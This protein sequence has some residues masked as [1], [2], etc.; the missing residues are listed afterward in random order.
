MH[1]S[2]EERMERLAQATWRLIA[3]RGIT[4]VSVRTVAE[5]AGVAVGSLRHLFPTQAALLEFSAKLMLDR[6]TARVTGI[7]SSSGAD[8]VGHAEAT[9]AELMPITPSTRR[10]FEISLALIAETPSTPG[11]AE[12]RDDAHRD[13]LELFA[14]IV[15]VLQES[16]GA[17]PSSEDE[18]KRLFAL[19]D[20]VSLHLLHQAA[21]EDTAWAQRI[22][23]DELV[24]IRHGRRPDAA[25][26]ENG[27]RE[28]SG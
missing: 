18:A 2:R 7:A 9:I 5:E 20:G 22:V 3:E 8:P 14:R 19:V 16:D 12:I 23:R 21:G 26:G 27:R 4:A 11:L 13:L 24:R 25:I 28:E 1:V 17:S 6:V 10:E 15:A